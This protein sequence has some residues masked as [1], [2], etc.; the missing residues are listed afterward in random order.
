MKS[1][2]EILQ[3]LA[4]NKRRF[5]RTYKV[6]RIGVFGSIVRGDASSTSDIDILVDVDPSIG[7]NFITLADEIERLLG[8]RVDVISRRAINPRHWQEIEQDV[9]YV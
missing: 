5:K 4:R 6:Q 1:C 9:V 8:E 7:L 3:L 2:Q